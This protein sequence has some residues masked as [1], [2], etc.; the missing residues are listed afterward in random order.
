MTCT[1]HTSVAATAACANCASPICGSCTHIVKGQSICPNC[2]PS[3]RQY[4]I[5]PV[6]AAVGASTGGPSMSAGSYPMPG[7]AGA[8]A[9]PPAS[10]IVDTSTAALVKARREDQMNLWKGLAVGFAIGLIG[11]ILT[12]KLLFYAHFGLA[13]LYIGIGWGIGAGIWHFT[14]RGGNQLASASVGVMM[15]SLFIAHFVLASDVLNELRDKGM[16]DSG[17]TV[18]DAFP[19]VMGMLGPMHWVCILIGV[20]AC[21]N[22]A[23][24]QPE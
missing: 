4:G 9:P 18:F 23:H 14:N 3:V 20:V 13:Y 16:A 5:Q 11:C 24:R 8:Y 10:P 12:E 1:I 15:L 19:V 6:A 17:A 2:A 22:A 7:T 21:F